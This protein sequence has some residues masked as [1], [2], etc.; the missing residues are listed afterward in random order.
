ADRPLF[1]G[2]VEGT[3]WR[4]RVRF[5]ITP[6]GVVGLR[7]HRSHRVVA[8]PDCLIAHPAVTAAVAGRR[9]PGVESVEVAVSPTTGSVSVTTTPPT[10]PGGFDEVGEPAQGG[11]PG[12]VGAGGEVVEVVR[13]R[14][15]WL[16]PSSFWQV[17]P[18]AAR[19]LVTAV[20]DGLAPRPGE[21]ALD[22]YSGAGLFAAF[23]AEAVGPTGKVIAMESDGAAVASAARSLEDVPQVSLRAVRVTPASVRG[24]LGRAAAPAA[25]DS[26]KPD[27]SGADRGTRAGVDLVVLDPPRAGAGPEVVAALL[28]HRPRAVAYVACDPASLG[29]DLAAATAAGYQLASLRAFAL[30]PMT[31]HVECVAILT[32]R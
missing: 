27:S 7:Q 25:A 28:A 10:V 13:G 24:A 12:L 20:L 17:H 15:F 19:T 5:A 8:A 3:G 32:A 22:L 21:V 30:F 29:R 1:A 31:S 23:L 14:R 4:T 18:G 6:D 16:D 9:F 26:S 2:E 11:D